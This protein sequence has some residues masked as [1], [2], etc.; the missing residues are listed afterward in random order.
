[1]QPPFDPSL[2]SMDPAVM[3]PILLALLLLLVIYYTFMVR[4]ILQ[5]LR[6]KAHTV[7]LVFSFVALVPFPLILIV[8]IMVLIIWS[9]HKHDLLPTS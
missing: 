5:M 6:A 8:G 3:I 2:M 9:R 4:A 1:M 7:L